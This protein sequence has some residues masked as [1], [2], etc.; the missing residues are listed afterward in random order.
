[1]HKTKVKE[2]RRKIKIKIKKNFFSFQDQ[3]AYIKKIQGL[4]GHYLNLF[5]YFLFLIEGKIEIFI[6]YEQ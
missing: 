2:K 1:M 5:F 6:K 4:L 3:I